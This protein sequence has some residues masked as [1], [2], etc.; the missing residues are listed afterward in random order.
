MNFRAKAPKTI[1]ARVVFLLGVLFCLAGCGRDPFLHRMKPLPAETPC[2]IAVLPLINETDYPLA[3]TIVYKVFSV[4][5]TE[6]GNFWL[7]QEGDIR[8][9]FQQF[10]IYPG[11]P[12]SPE[13]MKILADRLNVQLLITGNIIQMQEN[14]GPN[15]S[16]NP[17][18][19]VRLSI[20]NAD[21]IETLWSTYHRRQGIDYQT[22]MHFGQINSMTRLCRQV[23][24]EII[25]LWFEQGLTPC[26]ITSQY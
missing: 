5:L 24:K 18:L 13:Q 10:R 22:T 23:A 25:N 15:G 11:Q 16:V 7:A 6:M 8:K 4:E 20:L 26:D 12:L 19:A 2:R 14:P 3:E 9:I 21:T 17:E 1:G